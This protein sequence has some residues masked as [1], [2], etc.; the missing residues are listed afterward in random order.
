MR[1][2]G[3][4]HR[5]WCCAGR[6]RRREYSLRAVFHGL[7]YLMKTGHQWRMTPKDLPSWPVVYQQ[8]QRWIRAGCFEIL[9]EDL[10][11]LSRE[12]LGRKLL[13]MPTILD[14]R[15][16]RSTPG[17]E[18]GPDTT[19]SSA[20]KDPRCMRQCIPWDLC[21][22]Y[23]SPPKN[24]TERKLTARRRSATSHRKPCGGIHITTG[25]NCGC[26]DY[27]RTQFDEEPERRAGPSP[28]LRR[29]EYA[30]KSSGSSG[31]SK[32]SAESSLAS[33]NSMSSSSAS[34]TSPSS[35]KRFA[36]VNAP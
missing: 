5:I 4:W 21:W 16:I 1:S 23:M 10:S 22:R 26:D 32:A 34:S 9:V 31:D 28:S 35:S 2:G 18:R 13:P 12:S 3:L 7:R 17:W 36:S 20:A 14:S 11:S 30:T 19:T 15:T 33:R 27:P 8:T 6:M 29:V 25:T 24:R